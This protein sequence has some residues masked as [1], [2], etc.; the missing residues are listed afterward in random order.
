MAW[1]KYML[2]NQ[3]SELASICNYITIACLLVA[4]LLM[5]VAK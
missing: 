2:D 1:L 4:V 3:R 5:L